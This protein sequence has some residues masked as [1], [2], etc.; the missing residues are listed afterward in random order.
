[1]AIFSKIFKK[2][3][4]DGNY[5][6][7]LDIGTEIVKALV[8]KLDP[9]E[10]KG[11]V[12]GVGRARQKQG[13]MQSGMVTDIAGVVSTSQEAI[14]KAQE[15]AGV[16]V[17]QA[18][19]GIAGELVKGVTTVVHYERLKPMVKISIAE[20]KN[21]IQKVQ[22]KAFDK[23]RQQITWETGL[24]EIDVKLINAAIVDVKID[25]YR[26]TNP[27]G[28]QGKDVSMSIFNAYAPLVHLG[29]LQTIASELGLNLLSIADEPYAMARSLGIEDAL[30]FSAIFMDIGGGTTDIA[31]VRNGGVEGTKMFALGGRAF[32][33]RLSQDFGLNF[34]EAEKM[35]IKYAKGYL[36]GGASQKIEKIL[37]ED[38]Q[39]WLSGVELSLK[40]FSEADLLPSKILLCGGG[41]GLPDIEKVLKRT[42]WS[43][44]LAFAKK[45]KIT[46]IKPKE[47]KSIIDKTGMLTDP[48]DITPMALANLALDLVG[49]ENILS[50][51]LGKAVKMIQT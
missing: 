26:I 46:F 21:I 31:V 32:T 47:I 33:K 24:S 16:E 14:K 51:I 15:M 4:Y 40:E 3:N 17:S 23:I 1:M 28:F 41:S 29:A 50:K 11:I 49:E 44:E 12:K 8:F 19:I 6:L 43:E 27:L 22:W 25:G 18:V 34:D 36:D 38:C 37:E 2:K 30:E 35:K 7:A 10:R 45:P 42:A 9:E 39:V 48:A 5:A 20:L 13:D